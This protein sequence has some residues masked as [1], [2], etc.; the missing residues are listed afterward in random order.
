[1][2]N[3]ISNKN[4][5]LKFF[6]IALLPITLILGNFAT[7]FFLYFFI[8]LIFIQIF[9]TRN[10][11][12]IYI[13]N[14]KVRIIFYL[15]W[16]YLILISLFFHEHNFKSISKSILF[17][18][19]F[20][21]ALGLSNYL[22]ELEKKKM[23]IISIFFFSITVFIYFDLL[24]QFFNSENKD[25]FGFEVDNLRS[26][27]FLGK[28][29]ILA[30]RLSGP[31]KNELVPGFYLSTIG[32]ISIFLLFSLIYQVK[33]K[34]LILFL[35]I[36][37]SF[38]ILTGERSSM[39]M[40]FIT[41]FLFF[42]FYQKINFK[43]FINLFFLFFILV[44]FINFNPATKDRFRDLIYWTT[45]KWS[46]RDVSNDIKKKGVSETINRKIIV[47]NV[48]KTPWM[49]HY[50]ASIEIIIDK[51]LFGT[52]IRTFRQEC[53]KYYQKGCS[54]HPHHYILE[55][56][57]ETGLIFFILLLILIFLIIKEAW[58]N[59]HNNS[60]NLGILIIFLSYLFPL[61]PTGSFFSSWYGAFFWIILS[62]LF[63][64]IKITKKKNDQ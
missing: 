11:S 39:I 44:F 62:F 24:Y 52:G 40:N 55:I 27:K 13:N 28:D 42:L 23:K 7:N 56:I 61:R 35:L 38:V 58:K 30:T 29:V 31:F 19:H 63:F 22:L 3:I 36:N 5:D 51:P 15:S 9:F 41:I 49:E 8:F 50:K 32:C 26:F 60:F 54:T 33:N 48:L 57:S 45:E 47:D 6:Y 53:K 16:L 18:I 59:K 46:V 21:F 10:W 64:S 12:L 14:D 17:G 1:M 34:V 2:R 43:T 4:P 20:F 37:F 25:I